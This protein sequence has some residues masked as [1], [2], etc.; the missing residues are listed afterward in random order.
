MY[1]ESTVFTLA[2]RTPTVPRAVVTAVALVLLG[3]GIVTVAERPY[4]MRTD[5]EVPAVMEKTGVVEQSTL[6]TNE[7]EGA[8][9]ESASQADPRECD[10]ARGI[11]SA[12]VFE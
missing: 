2:R 6:P 5:V 7:A 8:T 9:A 12:C 3:Y 11:S 10:L 4:Q 1:M